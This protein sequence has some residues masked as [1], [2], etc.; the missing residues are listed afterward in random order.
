MLTCYHAHSDNADI[1]MFSWCSKT[2]MFTTI[3]PVSMEISLFLWVFGQKTKYWR[4]KKVRRSPKLDFILRGTWIC[5]AKGKH[6]QLLLRY[7]AQNQRCQACGSRKKIRESLKSA[8]FIIWELL[9]SIR[10]LVLNYLIDVEI[11]H[12]NPGKVKILNCWWTLM[13]SQELSKVRKIHPLRT[14]ICWDLSR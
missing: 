4:D 12:P 14:K 13:K 11:F 8:G 9:M 1:L 6:I 3:Q 10:N 2:T 5:V 7:F